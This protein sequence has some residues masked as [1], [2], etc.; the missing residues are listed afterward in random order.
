MYFKRYNLINKQITSTQP[1]GPFVSYYGKYA[2]CTNAKCVY[3]NN[4]QLLNCYCNVKKG[5]AVG[6]KQATRTPP[7]NYR[8]YHIR[9]N[10]YI[11]SLYSGINQAILAKQTC[12][13]GTWGDCLDKVCVIDKNNPSKA[14][15]SCTPYATSNWITFQYN[16]NKNTCGCNNLSGA[17]NTAYQNIEKYYLQTK[18]NNIQNNKNKNKNNKN[19]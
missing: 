5:L 19:K 7:Y 16:K 9:D 6:S 18:L 11:F 17:T 2:L 13:S 8:P 4:K 14:I 3:D 1:N 15:C 12:T 10:K